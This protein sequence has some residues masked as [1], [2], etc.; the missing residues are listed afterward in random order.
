MSA[1]IP[2]QPTQPTTPLPPYVQE[3]P[4]APAA[5]AAQSYT[6][7]AAADYAAP[8]YTAAKPAPTRTTLA[9][10]NTYALVA[11]ITAFLV[12]L[13][14][15]IFGHLALS[16]IKRTGDAGRG[17]ALTGLV[18]GYC[19]FA[20]GAIFILSYIGLIFMVIGTFASGN[21]SDFA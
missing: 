10:T 6:H 3:S 19:V 12:P 4:A 11:V 21:Y 7:Y 13:A 9:D 16:Q 1:N 8:E 15:I 18:Y 17:L 20:L 2:D 14:G 5:P